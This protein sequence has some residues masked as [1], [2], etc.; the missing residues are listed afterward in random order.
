MAI[1]AEERKRFE[2]MGE[3]RVRLEFNTRAFGSSAL[4]IYAGEWLAGI[5]EANRKHRE[6]ER[7]SLFAHQ[8]KETQR[9]E[10]TL[11]ATWIA[12]YVAIGAFI[13]SAIAVI[14]SVLSWLYPH[15]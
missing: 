5:D 7:K 9:S 15:H 1:P 6:T 11:K 13:F 12:V 2:D 4:Q 10:S 8:V 3:A 14:I